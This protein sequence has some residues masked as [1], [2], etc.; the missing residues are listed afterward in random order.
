M[1]MLYGLEQPDEGE[2]LVRGDQVIDSPARPSS[3]ASAWSTS[4]SCWST[5][6]PWPRTSCSAGA[7]PRRRPA[8]PGAGR[9][10]GGGAG[11]RVRHPLDPAPGSRTSASA[12]SSGSRSSSLYRGADILILDEPTAVLVPQEVEELFAHLRD[13]K[14][15]G[16]TIIFIAHSLDEVLQ[17]ADRITVL[18]D[19]KVIGT[20]S[21]RHR[22]PPGGR[23]DGRPP[24]AAA[25]GRGQGHPGE[26]LLR[27][28]TSGSPGARSWWPGSTWIVRRSEIYGLAG[29]EGNGQAELVEALVG[30]RTPD[31]GRIYL[32]DDELT[33]PTCAPGAR[34]A[35]PTSPR[36]ATPAAWSCRC[37]SARTRSSASRSAPFSRRPARPGAIRRWA[38]ELIRGF[39]VKARA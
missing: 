11:P 23:D 17:V 37:W 15:D 14:A 20:G 22:H 35:W 3:C 31:T 34:P 24:G 25:P 28:R 27:S 5:T 39:R 21:R 38:A 6:S 18:R 30:L 13:L 10:A 19:G 12:S 2:I 32:D 26:P 33:R 1:K 4:T 29:V 7:Q 8:R 16:K 36:T 9:A